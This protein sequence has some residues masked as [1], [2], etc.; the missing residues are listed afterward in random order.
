MYDLN[1]IKNTQLAVYHWMFCHCFYCTL[2]CSF[3]MY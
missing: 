3:I 1:I 2:L